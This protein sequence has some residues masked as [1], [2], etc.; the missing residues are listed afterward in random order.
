MLIAV[1]DSVSAVFI[2]GLPTFLKS[3]GF[4]VAVASAPGKPMNALS[5]SE[6]IDFFP[7][8]F[9]REIS[10]FSDL[11]ALFAVIRVIRKYR[12]DIVNA[13]TPKAAFICQIAAWLCRVPV[14]IYRFHGMRSATLKGLKKKIIMFTERTAARLAHHI[15]ADSPSLRFDAIELGIV[16]PEKCS[17]LNRG[18]AN[19]IDLKQFDGQGDREEIDRLRS[20]FGLADSDFVIGFLGRIVRDKGIVELYQAYQ[21]LKDK[22]PIKLLLVGPF[23]EGDPLPEPIV[24]GLKNDPNIILAGSVS[25]PENYYPLFNLLALPSYREG[26]GNAVIEAGAMGVPAVA[27]DVTGCRD[28][29]LDGVTGRICRVRDADDL[30]EKLEY[31]LR[32]PEICWKHGAEAQKVARA[33]FSNEQVWEAQYRIY[34]KLLEARMR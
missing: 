25:R 23:E 10:L 2:K 33:D 21:L 8:P 14:R 17:V 32:S 29:V 27:T 11:I 22:Y 24:E 5:E 15:F 20:V 30:T 19:G 3:K 7:L 31:Y 12:P 9:K 18:S 26:F 28:A 6:E 13:G 16:K 34:L 4:E 1:T